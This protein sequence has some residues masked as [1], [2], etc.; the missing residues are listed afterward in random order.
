MIF[1]ALGGHDCLYHQRLGC[2][3]LP[4]Y[5]L[6]YVN[7]LQWALLAIPSIAMAQVGVRVAHKL[8]AKQLKYVFIAVMI[9]M[10]L[11]MMGVFTFLGLPL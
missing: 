4:A 6:G 2:S 1:T 3:R 7:L 8:P 9:Y 11:K 10:G 5:S